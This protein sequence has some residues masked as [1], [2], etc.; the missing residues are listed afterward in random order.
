MDRMAVVQIISGRTVLDSV[1]S[2]QSVPV[3]AEDRI[4]G[5]PIP[6]RLIRRCIGSCLYSPPAIP[7][8]YTE[9]MA[10]AEFLTGPNSA[11]IRDVAARH[12]ATNVR[13]FGSFARG[14][15]R[16][17]SDLDLLVDLEPGR[18]VLDLVAIKQDLE[19]LLARRVDVVT[20]LS[21]SPYIRDSVLE[22]AISL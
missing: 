1:W 16:P 12:G 5:P 18:S 8:R 4:T 13:I 17:K 2:I 3:R 15:Q 19:D 20:L 21:L 9:G 11:T 22:D 7:R 10:V 6:P 14:T